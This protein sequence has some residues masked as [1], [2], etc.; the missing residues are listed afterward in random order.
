MPVDSKYAGARAVAVMRPDGAG[1]FRKLA[2]SEEKPPCCGGVAARS[3][4][5]ALFPVARRVVRGGAGDAST[6][7]GAE[8]WGQ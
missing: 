5:A 4:P 6:E 3:P 8:I 1:E 7:A 2:V